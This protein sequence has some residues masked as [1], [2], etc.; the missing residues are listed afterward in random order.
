MSLSVVGKTTREAGPE[1]GVEIY[2]ATL[3][4]TKLNIPA[5]KNMRNIG[6]YDR[7]KK[8]RTYCLL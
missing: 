8:G 7:E 5:V 4:L 2:L 1:S 6:I 3:L